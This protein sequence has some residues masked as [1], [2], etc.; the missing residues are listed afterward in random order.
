[1]SAVTSAVLLLFLFLQPTLF[2][3][4]LGYRVLPGFSAVFSH[5]DLFLL[6]LH[7]AVSGTAT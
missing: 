3:I 6:I 2:F 5:T 1:M 4:W 7:F